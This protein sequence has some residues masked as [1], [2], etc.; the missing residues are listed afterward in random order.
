MKPSE[1]IVARKH[2]ELSLELKK[3][4]IQE[5]EHGVPFALLGKKYHIATSTAANIWRK[6]EFFLRSKMSGSRKRCNDRSKYKLVNQVTAIFVREML[7]TDHKIDGEVIKRFAR[8]A[9][10]QCNFGDFHGSNGWLDSFK[11]RENVRWV[12]RRNQKNPTTANTN[13][14]SNDNNNNIEPAS[15]DNNSI[16]GDRCVRMGDIIRSKLGL[17]FDIAHL[18]GDR[19]DITNNNNNDNINNGNHHE[20]SNGDRII[21]EWFLGIPLLCRIFQE[22]QQDSKTTNNN[23][24]S[25]SNSNS[26]SSSNNNI[27]SNDVISGDN[28]T[29]TNQDDDID[30]TNLDL[31]SIILDNEETLSKGNLFNYETNSNLADKIDEYCQSI[32]KE[33]NELILLAS[34]ELEQNSETLTTNYALSDQ[35]DF[36][37]IQLDHN[38][39]CNN[40]LSADEANQYQENNNIPA[41]YTN[42]DGVCSYNEEEI[43]QQGDNGQICDNCS[44]IEDHHHQ[45][46][47]EICDTCAYNEAHHQQEMCDQSLIEE[48]LSENNTNT[49]SFPDNNNDFN[50]EDE[51]PLD[52][53]NVMR[54]MV[55]LIRYANR[56]N[57]CIM[58]L[59]MR[60][61]RSIEQDLDNNMEPL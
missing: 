1:T 7:Q 17:P 47:G 43:H 11:K 49:D 56:Y 34:Q 36:N 16:L 39:S 8:T 57:P 38:N 4:L 28:V 18:N 21:D 2:V 55:T 5:H 25:S 24:N 23:N 20:T 14:N 30:A 12:K 15:L 61:K 46:D 42:F 9:A 48:I 52:R 50:Y 44:Y 59:L 22:K 32:K 33:E 45:Q 51:I 31:R 35:R 26:N 53:F 41:M 19:Q 54:S 37:L 58:N 29:I 6:K 10:S 40:W 13:N 60:V 27:G 3:K